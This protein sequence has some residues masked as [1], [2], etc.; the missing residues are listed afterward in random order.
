MNKGQRY[1]HNESVVWHIDYLT[2]F[3]PSPRERGIQPSDMDM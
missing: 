3:P 2:P 1:I